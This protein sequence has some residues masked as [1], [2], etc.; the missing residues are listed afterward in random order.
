M[1]I[2]L[3]T[4]NIGNFDVVREIPK[5]TVPFDHFYYTGENLYFPGHT[6][7]NRLK[8]KIPKIIPHKIPELLMYDYFIWID[9]NI[10]IT[11]DKFV[12]LFIGSTTDFIISN[13]PSRKTIYEEADFII[14]Q[15]KGDSRYLKAR[16]E[17]NSIKK[18]M[19][20]INKEIIDAE[21]LYYCGVFG[22]YNYRKINDMC[23]RW[24]LD[25]VL[26]TNFDQLNFVSN[27]A[28][29]HISINTINFGGTFNKT[30]YFSV[31]K[32][33]KIA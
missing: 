24:Y 28:K 8:A 29:S 2:A 26:F 31:N 16:Y 25:N 21:G 9:A 13:H 33:N 32:H 3:I 11:S 7:D 1:K 12:E 27:A 10:Q 20:H 22:R 30:N 18:E 14:S 15:L 6:I 5:Q 4:A 17:I 23:E 19:E